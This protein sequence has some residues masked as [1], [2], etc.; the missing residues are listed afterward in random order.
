MTAT[1]SADRPRAA[2]ERLEAAEAVGQQLSPLAVEASPADPAE[3]PAPA[4]PGRPTGSRNRRTSQLR[5][6]L[7]AKGMRMPE[8]VV[9]ET[10]GL[11]ARVS[12]AELVITRAEQVATWLRRFPVGT[13]EGAAVG[14][15]EQ[16]TRGQMEGLFLAIYREQG[17]AAA[18][19]LPYGLERLT[20]DAAAVVA[21]TMIV[22]PQGGQAGDQARVIDGSS[23]VIAPPPRPSEMQRIQQVS[24]ATRVASD[25]RSRTE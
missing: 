20:P 4:G 15:G 8:D 10:A 21:P 18:A 5:Q 11:N 22:L 14:V 13:K 6:M 16:L 23:S 9:A 1:T 3:L 2:A 24:N 7:A 25:D 17:D 19:L 12:G